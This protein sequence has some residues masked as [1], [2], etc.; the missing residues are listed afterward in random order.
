[1]K[2]FILDLAARDRVLQLAAPLGRTRATILMAHRFADAERGT[3]GLDPQLFRASLELLRRY[4]FDVVPLAQLVRRLRDGERLAPR[5]V[6]FTVDDGYADYAR[7]AAPLFAAYDCP[8]TVFVTTGFIDGALWNWWD[9]VE[10]TILRTTRRSF[11]FEVDGLPVREAWSSTA[12]RTLV[13]ARVTEL[14]KVVADEHKERAIAALAS[15]LD[16]LLPTDAPSEYAAMTWDEVRACE[17]AGTSV[18]P[19]TVT[20][21]VLSRV[22]AATAAAEI[23]G[24]WARLQ[25][26][27]RAPDPVFCYPSGTEDSFSERDRAIVRDLGL[28]GAVSSFPGY[29]RHRDFRGPTSPRL[30][31]IPRFGYPEHERL[32]RHTIF[33]LQ[34]AK[35]WLRELAPQWRTRQESARTRL[36]SDHAV[37]H[38]ATPGA[39]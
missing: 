24:S 18:G 30:F 13:Q 32:F 36:V 27:V 17:R 35:L 37:L 28:L 23:R 34:G 10:Y 39:H 4:R 38:A 26:E 19:H 20:H 7:I 6:A 9:K 22:S 31:D 5:T 14:L 11:A 25:Q 1:M 8:A 15:A 16:V 12:E 3:P 21:P 29:V 33:G 2:Q